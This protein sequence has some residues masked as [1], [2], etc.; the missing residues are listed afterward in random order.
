MSEAPKQLRDAVADLFARARDTLT[1][2]GIEVKKEDVELATDAMTWLI[3]RMFGEQRID[4]VMSFVDELHGVFDNNSVLT[5]IALVHA[6]MERFG[7]VSLRL[8]TLGVSVLLDVCSME[9]LGIQLMVGFSIAELRDSAVAKLSEVMKILNKYIS[10]RGAP[11][12]LGM[13][14]LASWAMYDGVLKSAAFIVRNKQARLC[15][16]PVLF[17]V[18][19]KHNQ[20]LDDL[21]RFGY[22]VERQRIESMILDTVKEKLRSSAQLFGG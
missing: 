7:F 15:F 5:M 2:L 21:K 16:D 6:M 19:L 8:L 14:Y 10:E 1:K 11:T 9:D 4:D 12:V 20:V 17:Y 18:G 22:V 13:S 3:P